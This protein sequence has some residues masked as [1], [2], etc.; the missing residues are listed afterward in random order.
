MELTCLT[1]LGTVREPVF[2][3]LAHFFVSHQYCSILKRIFNIDLCYSYWQDPLL[4]KFWEKCTSLTVWE[5][6]V[7]VPLAPDFDTKLTMSIVWLIKTWI[8]PHEITWDYYEIKHLNWA[9]K[10]ILKLEVR[11]PII[12]LQADVFKMRLIVK[13]LQNGD[14]SITADMCYLYHK[15][16]YFIMITSDKPYYL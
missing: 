8:R 14:F 3:T 12:P 11:P 4:S 7:K 9:N 1:T 2:D 6:S 13:G 10:L 5:I 16:L 15:C